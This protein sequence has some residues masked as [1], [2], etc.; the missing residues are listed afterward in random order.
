MASKLIA[1]EA[2]PCIFAVSV[3][4]HGEITNFVSSSSFRKIQRYLDPYPHNEYIFDGLC[5][6]RLK[7]PPR[8]VPVRSRF[9][10]V[11]EIATSMPSGFGGRPFQ[12]HGHP[13]R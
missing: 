9:S 11:A 1:I 5:A 3:F 6:G 10:T 8:I 2:R 7:A 13:G 12:Q 4:G